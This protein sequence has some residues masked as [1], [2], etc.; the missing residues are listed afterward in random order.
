MISFTT[1]TRGLT[2]MNKY[3]TMSGPELAKAYN[4]MAATRPGTKTVAKFRDRAT[5]LK[6]CKDLES[7]VANGGAK[8]AADAAATA[9]SGKKKTGK[10][11]TKK[12]GGITGEFGFRSGSSRE[13]LLLTLYSAMGKQV[14]VA[15]LARA[16]LGSAS[17]AKVTELM[18]VS[19]GLPWRI[20]ESK[21]AYEFKKEKA[22]DGEI[23]LGL[24]AK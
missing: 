14:A 21:L 10:T 18:A 2:K 9:A 16:V 15:S 8:P 6:R 5:A 22:K 24:H 11:T 3:E 17:E 12:A 20:K 1:N 13:K 7:A 23:T 4:A 19:K